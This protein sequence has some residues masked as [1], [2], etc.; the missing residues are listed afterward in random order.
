MVRG[1]EEANEK[2]DVGQ[3]TGIESD[4]NIVIMVDKGEHELL[5]KLISE[6]YPVPEMFFWENWEDKGA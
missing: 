4:N 5:K 2:K 6:L 3:L 1:G